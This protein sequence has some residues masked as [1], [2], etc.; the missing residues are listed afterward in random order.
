MRHK[1]TIA[2]LLVSSLIAATL[3]AAV[4]YWIGWGA[5][6]GNSESH[7]AQPVGDSDE[8]AELSST[9]VL[10][11]AKWDV[12]GIR[13]EAAKQRDVSQNIWVTGKVALNE[14]RLAQIDPLVEGMVD[15]VKVQFGDEVQAGQVLA[16]VD[17]REVGQAK[18]DLFK[19]RLATRLATVEAEWQQDVETNVQSLIDGLKQQ[20]PIAEIE[21]QFAD[22]AMGSYR[23]QL[24]SAYARLHKSL[25]DH[26]RLK[27][28]SVDGT[29][30]RK[31]FIA[32]KAAYEA[33]QAML[34]ALLEQIRFTARK[35]RLTA[36]Q[37][38]EQARTA[39]SI[40]ATNLRIMGLTDAVSASD[41]TKEGEAV[42]H[43]PIKAPF[44]GTII[45]KDVVLK[46]RVGPTTQ[47]FAIADL[48]TVWVAADIYE[49]HMAILDQLKGQVVRFRTSVYPDRMFEARVFST[50]SVVSEQSRTL[51][52]RA[53]AENPQRLLK[54]GMFVEV[55]LPVESVADA[56]VVP[57]SA[58]Q[59]HDGKKC[60]FVHLSGDQ[61]ARRDV[62]VGRS[63]GGA[64]EIVAGLHA[65][66]VLVVEG[67][68]FL[69]SQMLAEQFADE[70]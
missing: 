58:L 45:E 8:E 53:L 24:V 61:F 67:G 39:E 23:E 27:D 2:L 69:K 54:P 31:D 50:G 38:L 29:I 22:K 17:S 6:E 13:L 46:E 52:M 4:M 18:L 59:E 65:G 62:S 41:P 26:E 28:L 36:D 3:G 1:R 11:K 40:S 43:Y 47:L 21:Q 63:F 55:E 9:I 44:D 68:F 33:D 70:D 12:A 57:D 51:P 49:R 35:T 37:T 14:D 10:P 64:V 60:V 32:A 42:S 7:A 66:D 34:Q 30:A 15:E 20:I 56:L 5:A 25:A 48:S 16:I 19:N